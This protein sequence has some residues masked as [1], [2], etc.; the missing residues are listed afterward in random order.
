MKVEIDIEINE[1]IHI[2]SYENYIRRYHVFFYN[3]V[4]LIVFIDYKKTDI[5]MMKDLGRQD[6]YD[7]INIPTRL[8]SSSFIEFLNTFKLIKDDKKSF[9]YNSEQCMAKFRTI[10]RN[11]KIANILN[12]I[13]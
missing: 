11:E 5:T 4:Y 3:Y 6:D 8:V 2:N 7:E 12:N 13:Q 9:S 10:C 1:L